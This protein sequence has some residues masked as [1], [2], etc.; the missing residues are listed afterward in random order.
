MAA[1]RKAAA[2]RAS[3]RASEE[4]TGS[5][6][7]R[8]RTQ[9]E[10]KSESERSIIKAAREL[11]A[12][13]GYV[14]TTLADVGKLAGYT[15]GL[16]SHRFGSKQDLLREV[17]RRS[18]KRFQEDQIEPVLADKTPTEAM[19][20]FIA[21]YLHEVAIRESRVRALYVIMGEALGAVEEIQPEV[22]KL[23]KGFRASLARMI[24]EGIAT[25][26]FAGN[27][28]PKA[29]A[30]LILGLLR[31]VTMQHLADPKSARLKEIVPMVQR[32]ALDALTH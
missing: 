2:T 12:K 20:T 19:K 22:A 29:A 11:F 13:Q 14:R 24:E 17:F 28:D 9:E 23:N 27:I 7:P 4:A 30:F 5:E 26:E 31:G 25:G 21:T 1:S 3:N 16:V 18:S 10:R 15:G 6:R 8:R 32:A